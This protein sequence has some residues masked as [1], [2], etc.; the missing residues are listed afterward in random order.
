[1]RGRKYV[2][3]QEYW[4]NTERLGKKRDGQLFSLSKSK[5]PEQ[6]SESC[7]YQGNSG[8]QAAIRR[9]DAQKSRKYQ[10]WRC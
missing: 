6:E 7:E 3:K 9:E 1:M 10:T 5:R 2:V 8:L 4:R